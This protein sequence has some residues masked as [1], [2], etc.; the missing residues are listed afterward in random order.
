MIIK[1]GAKCCALCAVFFTVNYYLLMKLY[2]I[3]ANS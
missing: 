3:T 2:I 1:Y